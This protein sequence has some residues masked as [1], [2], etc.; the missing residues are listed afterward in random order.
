MA[1]VTKKGDLKGYGTVWYHVDGIANILS[2]NNVKKKY[3]VTFDSDLED[4]FVV[5]KGNG[6]K[7]VFKPSKKR[8]YDVV[9]DIG[10]SLVTTVD[11]LKNKYSVRQYS[12]AKRAHHLQD[13]IGRPSTNDLIKYIEGNIIPNCILHGKTSYDP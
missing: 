5:H 11:S 12:N 13:A 8:L 10:T 1:I 6:S 7:H 4:R 3:W 9:N 2:L